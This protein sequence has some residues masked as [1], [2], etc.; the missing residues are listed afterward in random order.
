M[1]FVSREH[2]IEIIKECERLYG[3]APPELLQRI[4]GI[5]SFPAPN[6]DESDGRNIMGQTDEE[7][8]GQVERSERPKPSKPPWNYSRGYP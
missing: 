2:V 3:A 1:N 4:E 7:F 6:P 5:P 8:W